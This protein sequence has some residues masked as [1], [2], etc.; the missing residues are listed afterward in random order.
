MAG[1]KI[2]SLAQRFWMTPR[3]MPVGLSICLTIRPH[4]AFI[5]HDC[6]DDIIP[7]SFDVKGASMARLGVIDL[8]SN[9]IRLVIYETKSDRRAAK[10]FR[11]LVDEKKIVGLSSYMED[12][13]LSPAGIEKAIDV[14][15]GLLRLAENLACDQVGIFATAA[16]RNCSN[17][18]A[19]TTA[20]EKAIGREVHVL[21]AEQEAHLGFVGA[22]IGYDLKEGTL[23]D[24]G[25]GSAEL[26]ALR[27]CGDHAGISLP[28][29]CVTFYAQHV[30]TVIPT[31]SECHAMRQAA[32]ALLDSASNLEPYRTEHAFG[33][34][35]SMRAISKM[36]AQIAQ[37]SEK[38]TTISCDDMDGLFD[39]LASDPSTFAHA[40]VKAAPDRV[41][42]FVPGMV[43]ARTILERL[44]ASD[45]S[46][47]KYGIREGY[48]MELIRS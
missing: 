31:L 44:G 13:A 2:T 5:Q 38:P 47:C 28:A 37:S 9:S 18:K 42:S 24:I 11:T 3:P 22:S 45:V 19:A 48:L 40:L 27:S 23:I 21:T 36:L 30:G 35:G 32:D 8:G 41:H 29:G 4:S 33:I 39:L 1:T 16:L 6:Y 17:S 34:G 14:L 25:G 7:L 46:L 43:I 10:P 20:I 12:G 26:S 15:N